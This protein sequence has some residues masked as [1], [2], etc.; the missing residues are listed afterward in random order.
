M[1]VANTDRKVNAALIGSAGESHAV[2]VAGT[3]EFIEMLSSNLY[4][5]PKEAMIR[6]VLCNA[7]DAHK[8]AGY[9]GPIEIVI[10]DDNTL[11][12]R[13]RGLGIPHD[14][15][16]LIYG[17]YGG[18]TKKKDSMATGGF[19]LGCKSPWSYTDAFTVANCHAGTK[20]INTM[21]RVSNDHGGLPAI[22]PIANFPTDE[23]GL[24][25]RIDIKPN[26]I[27][28]IRGLI[29][30]AVHRGGMNATLNGDVLD[31]IDYP[32]D[33]SYVFV[34]N[35]HL[36]Q[37]IMVK[38]GAVLYPVDDQDVYREF[39]R[40]ITD[41]L[42]HGQTLILLAPADSL[43]ISPNR[44]NVSY[45]DKTRK[46]LYLLLREFMEEINKRAEPYAR[47][48]IRETNALEIKSTKL[49][50]LN[51]VHLAAWISHTFINRGKSKL[52]VFG[53]VIHSML[54]LNYPKQFHKASL[55]Q[56]FKLSQEYVN[57]G[58][59]RSMLQQLKYAAL[60]D[61]SQRSNTFFKQ[62][63][64]RFMSLSRRMGLS[65]SQLRFGEREQIYMRGSKYNFGRHTS[66]S[67][68]IEDFV[69]RSMQQL[70]DQIPW[71]QPAVVL[72]HTIKGIDDSTVRSTHRAFFAVV[73]PRSG[74]S[75]FSI[76]DI[77]AY[78]KKAGLS[79]LDLTPSQKLL[80]K[81]KGETKAVKYPTLGMLRMIKATT[82]G[83][84]YILE[85]AL[86]LSV[87]D[88]GCEKPLA[89]MKIAARSGTYVTSPIG[90]HDDH[91]QKLVSLI[92]DDTAI[93]TTEA[94][95]KK[96]KK[97]GAIDYRQ[98]IYD[99]IAAIWADPKVRQAYAWRPKEDGHNAHGRSI[100][101]LTSYLSSPWYRKTFQL[102]EVDLSSSMKK[103][104]NL[105]YTFVLASHWF[106]TVD[107]VVKDIQN[108]TKMMAAMRNNNE[109]WKVKYM[110]QFI[111]TNPL[112]QGS[113]NVDEI[114]K[115]KSIATDPK[116]IT[117]LD[118]ILKIVME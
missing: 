15:M 108:I 53:R 99:Q 63:V 12:I 27:R 41:Y 111:E 81:A 55:K 32:S 38:Y 25:V 5:R 69:Y 61:R 37:K 31:R 51:Q 87:K 35:S 105:L 91:F 33:Q 64:F 104:L 23:T 3:R 107:E 98:M 43:I 82:Y 2:Q 10:E 71:L 101:T 102:P 66:T 74:Q 70:D 89:Y 113:V 72:T 117:K 45:L 49:E 8:D 36:N 24:E 7:D 73:I 16:H 29:I 115:L 20:T 77:S 112:F 57:P 6:E 106:L 34:E 95:V 76:A 54:L 88:N 47:Q 85:K 48:L 68:P 62:A 86:T 11:I 118:Q 14:K 100:R 56:R 1:E 103:K 109:P 39:Y 75:R 18:S 26:D 60:G 92:H 94:E 90:M 17:T 52:D 19:G 80:T 58:W 46:Q 30:N 84:K 42:N 9:T 50:W 65:N 21:L 110:F 28:E 59:E 83:D 4:S 22:I 93:V 79:V 67:V 44:E 114:L 13:D 116:L 40:M 96:L 97:L 78:Y